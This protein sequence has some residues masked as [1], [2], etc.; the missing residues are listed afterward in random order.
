MATTGGNW[1]GVLVAAAGTSWVGL[2]PITLGRGSC[3]E[4]YMGLVEGVSGAGGPTIN[5]GCCCCTDWLG[6][7]VVNTS[8]RSLCCG[9]SGI[10]LTGWEGEMTL[11]KLAK[12]GLQHIIYNNNNNSTWN[13]P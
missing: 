10:C 5:G 12:V 2:E 11:G 13:I 8:G 3:S 4:E 6:V 7:V 1:G 9:G